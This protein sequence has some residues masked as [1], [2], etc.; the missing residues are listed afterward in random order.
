MAYPATLSPG[1]RWRWLLVC[2]LGM[3][4][5]A[6]LGVWQLSRARQKIDLQHAIDARE[7]Q[8]AIDMGDLA[9]TPDSAAQHLYRMTVARGRW[10]AA[11][12]VYLQNRSW[13]D[14]QGVFH[15]GFQVVTPL[16]IAPG[17]AVLVQ[18]GWVPLD[19]RHWDRAPAVVTPSTDVRVQGRIV[20][21]PSH[22]VSFS[23]HE[24]GPIRQNV[25]LG[26]LGA[27]TGLHFLPWSIQET[28]SEGPN[29]ALVHEWPRPAVNVSMHYGYA[30]Q[31]FA[32]CALIA[33]LYVWFHVLA[34]RRRI[35]A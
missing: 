25:D 26:Q 33:I 21:P 22:W 34:P 29:D 14:A 24:T 4:L 35:A 30:F 9:R 6:S 12:T 10:V 17:Q 32:L 8:P 13:Q 15:P 11:D 18:R 20:P 7:G 5:T 23:D 16:Q 27:Q 2:L 28:A 19:P 3:A 31:W 1:R